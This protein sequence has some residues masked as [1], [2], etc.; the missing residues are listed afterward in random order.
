MK[1]IALGIVSGFAS[2]VIALE[3]GADTGVEGRQPQRSLS[4]TTTTYIIE[5]AKEPR[6]LD[7]SDLDELR[8]P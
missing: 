7:G 8:S 4:H 1:W 5:Q 6:P 3:L 2:I